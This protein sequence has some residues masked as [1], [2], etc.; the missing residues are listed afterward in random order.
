[1]HDRVVFYHIKG[2]QLTRIQNHGAL[3]A[4]MFLKQKRCGKIKGRTA[5]DGQEQR[6]GLKK[7]DVP[8]STAAT[9]LVLVTAAIDAT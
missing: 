7:S 9:E 8:S 5:A 4:L 3:Q 2:E 1:M 6:E